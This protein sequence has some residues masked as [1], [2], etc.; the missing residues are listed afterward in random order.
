MLFFAE[1]AFLLIKW[2]LRTFVRLLLSI[3][4]PIKS[5]IFIGSSRNSCCARLSSSK[6][7][8]RSSSFSV[9]SFKA[10]E[11]LEQLRLLFIVLILWFDLKLRV[12]CITF[13]GLCSTFPLKFVVLKYISSSQLLFEFIEIPLLL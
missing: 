7:K 4:D 8:C 12:L 13:D 6:N 1:N 10:D 3:W 11:F 5:S 2:L 9:S